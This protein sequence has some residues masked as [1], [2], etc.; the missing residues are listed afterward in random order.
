MNTPLT[1]PTS[2][3]GLL[4]LNY[5]I[6]LQT[7]NGIYT[8]EA[9]EYAKKTYQQTLETILNI[10]GVDAKHL[11]SAINQHLNII[12]EVNDNKECVLDFMNY[13]KAELHDIKYP[14]VDRLYTF[15]SEKQAI[16]VTEVPPDETTRAVTENLEDQIYSKEHWQECLQS[17]IDTNGIKGDRYIFDEDIIGA[18]KNFFVGPCGAWRNKA[19]LAG[20]QNFSSLEEL[21]ETILKQSQEKDM[22]LYMV[23][24][25]VK[26]EYASDWTIQNERPMFVWRGVFLDKE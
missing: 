3:A 26:R 18:A 9:K 7:A 4:A 24:E 11:N 10:L 16:E 21:K 12:K 22:M 14:R 8:Q 6:F 2:I 25:T 13:V 15:N 17:N 19:L 23:Y 5:A 20:T 1:P